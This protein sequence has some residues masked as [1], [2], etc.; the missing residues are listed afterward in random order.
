MNNL[1]RT[2]ALALFILVMGCNSQQTNHGEE[3]QLQISPNEALYNEVMHVHDEVMPKMNDLYKVR[4]ELQTRLK[5]PGLPEHDRKE[6]AIRIAHIDSASEGMMVWMRHFD[7]PADSLGEDR[8]RAYLE[9]ELVKV[10]KVREE[11]LKALETPR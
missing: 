10:K 4:N 2:S 1:L 7:P 3:D 11:I 5:L 8:A 9:R 6:I